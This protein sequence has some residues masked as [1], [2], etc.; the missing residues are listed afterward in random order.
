MSVVG[1]ALGGEPR[2]LGIELMAP[3]RLAG[4]EGWEPGITPGFLLYPGAFMLIP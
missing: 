3:H 4:R 2:R 1:G